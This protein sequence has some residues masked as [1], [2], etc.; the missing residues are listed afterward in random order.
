MKTK[1]VLAVIAV[2]ALSFSGCGNKNAKSNDN[3]PPIVDAAHNSRNSLDYE[4]TYTGTMP[5]ADC[6]GIK[7]ELTLKTNS[8]TLKTTYEG[9][10]DKSKDFIEGGEFAWNEAGS[11]ITLNNDSC[12]QYQV[13]ENKL[14][15]LD[16]NGKRITGDLADMYILK[17]N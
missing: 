15:A 16:L 17:K 5:C 9:T 8:Y 11:I 13:G 3:T 6:P 7:V 10:E 12:Q 2:L 14:I 1:L 4:G